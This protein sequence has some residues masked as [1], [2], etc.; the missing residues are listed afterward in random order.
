MTANDRKKTIDEVPYTLSQE[1]AN[2]KI[3]SNTINGQS[4][5]IKKRKTIVNVTGKD[6][7]K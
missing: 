5:E 1:P 6:Q 3:T 4:V 2:E 7:I